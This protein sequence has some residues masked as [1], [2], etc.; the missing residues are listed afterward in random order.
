MLYKFCL[1]L[2]NIQTKH[3]K[4]KTIYLFFTMKIIVFD[5]KICKSFCGNF[6]YIM[7]K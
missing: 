1:Q 2:K 6:F 4:I 3:L 5:E 7:S